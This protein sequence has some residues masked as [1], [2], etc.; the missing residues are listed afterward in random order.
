MRKTDAITREAVD[1]EH[2]TELTKLAE[3]SVEIGVNEITGGEQ[4]RDAD[5]DG[6]VKKAKTA[7]DVN[8]Q[9]NTARKKKKA[10][11]QNR[12]KSR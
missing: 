5:F 9:R 10:A 8:R 11:R 12:R 7:A 2:E 1:D 6:K 4:N 3:R